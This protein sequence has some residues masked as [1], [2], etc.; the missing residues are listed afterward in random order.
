MSVKMYGLIPPK[1]GMGL[2]EFH[3]YYRHPHG[4]MGR[5]L[6]T[7]RGYYQNHRIETDRL[8]AYD[9]PFEAVAEI[10]L[11]NVAD[12]VNF[13]EEPVLVKY[14]IED[15]PK[16]VDMDRLTFFAGVSEVLTSGPRWNIGLHPGDEMWNPARSPMSVKILQFILP[17]GNAD[18]AQA[19]DE[20]LGE[21]LGV[22]RHTR[23]RPIAEVHDNAPTFIGLREL[24][25]PTRLEFHKSAD[26]E[27]AALRAL[28]DRGGRSV[29]MLAQAERFI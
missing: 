1:P 16:F 29:T 13:R 27:P 23:A 10:W 21:K 28:L 24:W 8:P 9:A 5:H 11:D 26:R 14:L 18:W 20:A 7:M 19:D 17:D 25:W 3:D 15:E 2:D 4:T 12:A 22:F 6:S